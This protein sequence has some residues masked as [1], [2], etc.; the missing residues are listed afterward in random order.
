MEKPSLQ[1]LEVR[2]LGVGGAERPVW[3]AIHRHTWQRSERGD[4]QEAG[5]TL[6]LK[7]C[8]VACS[9]HGFGDTAEFCG[10]YDGRQQRVSITT[11]H[12]DAGAVIG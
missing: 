10:H 12:L 8:D 2:A 5:I 7:R 6:L 9:E 3:L 4:L 11:L 1:L